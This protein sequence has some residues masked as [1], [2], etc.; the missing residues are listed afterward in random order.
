VPEPTGAEPGAAFVVGLPHAD[1]LASASSLATR[2]DRVAI[3]VEVP[4]AGAVRA[5]RRSGFPIDRVTFVDA[6][7]QVL[8]PA[9]FAGSARELLARARHAYYVRQDLERGV[10][11]EQNPS[12]RPWEE[13]PDSLRESNR[14]FADSIGRRLA[15]LGAQL[16]PLAGP[17]SV[18][19]LSSALIEELARVEHDRWMNDLVSKGWRHHEGPKDADR[20]LHPLITDWEHLDEHEREKDRDGIR[21]LPELLARVGYELRIARDTDASAER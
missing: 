16:A 13:L 9:L 7:A 5:L 1:A 10:T 14:L 8:G 15:D 18:P 20:K 2:L 12:L 6:E 21:A 4:R 19:D 3:L 11:P 17:V